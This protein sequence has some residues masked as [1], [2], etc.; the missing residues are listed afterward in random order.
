LLASTDEEPLANGDQVLVEEIRGTVAH[1][2]RATDAFLP[3]K[4]RR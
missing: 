3:A 1:V 2:S 4:P